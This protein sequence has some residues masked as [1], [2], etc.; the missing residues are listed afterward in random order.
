MQFSNVNYLIV[1]DYTGYVDGSCMGTDISITPGVFTK[2]SSF[3]ISHLTQLQWSLPFFEAIFSLI[4][5][6][7]V[8]TSNVT[9]IFK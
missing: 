4:I 9:H 8:K 6:L 5:L 2:C 7:H 1:Y 3:Q